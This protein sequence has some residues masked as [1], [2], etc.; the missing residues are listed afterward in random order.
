MNT[1]PQETLAHKLAAFLRNSVSM[2]TSVREQKHKL[3][4]GCIL[5]LSS[6]WN[7][8]FGPADSLRNVQPVQTVHPQSSC[9]FGKYYPSRRDPSDSK[10]KGAANGHFR[11]TFLMNFPGRWWKMPRVQEKMWR[12][13]RTEENTTA[14][15]LGYV[16]MQW[17]MLLTWICCGDI[18]LL[19]R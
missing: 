11:S 1:H 13:M 8:M 18:K 3:P 5:F 2:C 7:K 14:L 19:W 16:I 9:T 17:W 10:V 4:V 15:T 12:W 6:G